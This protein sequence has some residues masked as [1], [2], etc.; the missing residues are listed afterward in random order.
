MAAM[1]LDAARAIG[2]PEVLMMV[3]TRVS[4]AAVVLGDHARARGT[5]IEALH[6]LSEIGGRGWVA[7]SLEM[8][9]VVRGA[10]AGV[11]IATAR[12]LGA[13]QGI[14]DVTGESF[15]FPYHHARLASLTRQTEA[16]LGADF[17]HEL[18]RGRRL[19]PEEAVNLALNQLRSENREHAGS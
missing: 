3:L 9:A 18:E 6:L 7:P 10:T 4:E 15:R 11:S 19:P 12:L 5:L 1:A 14:R 16:A 2:L 8:A 13:A 17:G